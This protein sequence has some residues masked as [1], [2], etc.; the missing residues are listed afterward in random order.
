MN[1]LETKYLKYYVRGI[2]REIP[3]KLSQNIELDSQGFC[4][5]KQAFE[6]EPFP[7]YHFSL[8]DDA[9]DAMCYNLASVWGIPS[10]ILFGKKLEKPQPP[11]NRIPDR[12]V[13]NQDKGKVTVLISKHLD[14]VAPYWAYTVKTS[15][16][17]KYDAIFGFMLAYFK[18]L[19]RSLEPKEQKALIE[20]VFKMPQTKRF[21][22]LMGVVDQELLKHL[23]TSK[24]VE[25]IILAIT[26]PNADMNYNN[27]TWDYLEWKEML[28][29][30]E[31]ETKREHQKEINKQIKAHQLEI[32]K[33]KGDNNKK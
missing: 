27:V 30:H 5:I 13:F 14:G 18:Y 29:V 24:K 25:E 11:K 1:E 31:L 32:D 8:D 16:N 21:P 10:E 28:R 12:V 33:L 6:R 4:K 2:P 20:R 9:L 26:S 23:G 7:Y 22:Y 19:N 3:I 15:E 17:D